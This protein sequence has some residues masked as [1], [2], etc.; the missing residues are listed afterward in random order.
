MR[1][2]TVIAAAVFGMTATL[3]SVYAVP[4]AVSLLLHIAQL[5]TNS[6]SG[7]EPVG[8]SFQRSRGQ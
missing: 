5:L 6:P 2:T 3:S 4:I 7:Y 1:F 8:V